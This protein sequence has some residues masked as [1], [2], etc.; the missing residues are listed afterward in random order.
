LRLGERGEHKLAE[1]VPDQPPDD[2]LL[3]VLAS[4]GG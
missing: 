3:D 4:L 1:M 2:G